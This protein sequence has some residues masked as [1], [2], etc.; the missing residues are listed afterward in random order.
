[1]NVFRVLAR[2]PRAKPAEPGGPLFFPRPFQGTGRHDN[3]DRY[4]CLYVAASAASAIAEALAPFRGSG[5]LDDTMLVRSGRRVALATLDLDDTAELVDLD[6]PAV[7][8]SEALRPSQ[9][10]TRDRNVTQAGAARLHDDHPAAAGLRWWSTLEA[11]WPNLTL[12]DRATPLLTVA[13]ERELDVADD[14]VREAG[15]L[16]GLFSTR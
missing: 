4:G 2:D 1:V 3:P 5:T 13:D 8:V 16:L 11:S 6:D 15:E 10:A 14:A 9:V 7:L 12:F